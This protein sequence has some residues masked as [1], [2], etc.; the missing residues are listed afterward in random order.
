MRLARVGEPGDERAAVVVGSG[1][2]LV[3]DL[4]PRVDSAFL[5]SGGLE[6]LA[7]DVAA[8]ALKG[9]PVLADGSLRYGPPVTPSKIVCI[10]LNYADHA[11]ETGQLPPAEPIIFMKAPN[12]V[13]GPDDDVTVPP[14][15]EKTDYEVELAVV[16]GKRSAYLESP[17]AARSAVAGYAVSDDISERHWQL[18]RGG[19]W[20]K[21]KCFATFNPLGPWLV[22]PD[23]VPHVQDLAL[24]LKVNGEPRQM[25]STE[26]M[27][28]S[29]DHVVWYVSQFMTLEPGDVINTGTPYGVGMGFDPPR[30]LSVGDTVEVE[31]AGLGRQRH[32]FVAHPAAETGG[33]NRG[34]HRNPGA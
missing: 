14:G 10:G 28:F 25:S 31:I 17:D 32:R 9:R 34:D 18:E 1:L 13:V 6:Q 2:V 5:S 8:G 3:D 15:S 20:D 33:P 16:I 30:Y 19:Q 4:V 26:Q 29:V 21:G 27:L 23:E 11:R 22:T 24:H 12:C 7:L